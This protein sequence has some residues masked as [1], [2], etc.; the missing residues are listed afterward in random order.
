MKKKT[1]HI[2][3]DP[4]VPWWE[5]DQGDIETRPDR[6]TTKY[7]TGTGYTTSTSN[8]ADITLSGNFYTFDRWMAEMTELNPQLG[9]TGV[10][11]YEEEGEIEF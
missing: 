7:S 11:D 6:F 4:P 5:K 3:I 1:R 2:P 10:G 8:T 9:E